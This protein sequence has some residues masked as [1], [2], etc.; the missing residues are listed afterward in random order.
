[1]RAQLRSKMVSLARNR[2][3]HQPCVFA[4]RYRITG[5]SSRRHA[6]TRDYAEAL[7]APQRGRLPS[8]ASPLYWTVKETS[9]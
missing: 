3:D 4:L 5:V 7:G 2:H 1:M 9:P 8:L 6:E